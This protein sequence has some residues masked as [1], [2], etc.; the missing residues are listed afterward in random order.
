MHKVISAVLAC[1]ILAAGIS[2]LYQELAGASPITAHLFAI[3]GLLS[4]G[5]VAWLWSDW[6]TPRKQIRRSTVPR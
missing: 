4:T 3:G 2:L 6:S 5:G 1:V